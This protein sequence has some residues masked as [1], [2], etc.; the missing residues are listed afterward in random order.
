M[1]FASICEHAS[2]AYFLASTGTDQICLACSEHFRKYNWRTANTSINFPL[3]LV[4]LRSGNHF[5]SRKIWIWE[6]NNILCAQCERRRFYMIYR[7][8]RNRANFN[9]NPSMRAIAKILRAR[10][11][12]HS[13]KFCEQIEQR[14]NL[15]SSWKFLWPFDTSNFVGS[16][17]HP[18]VFKLI[19]FKNWG[20]KLTL[21][22][23]RPRNR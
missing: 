15:A 22:I 23:F 9:E 10:A 14:P 17:T 6:S 4:V 21:T 20:K 3:I 2:T 12:E 5:T 13:A 16:A 1:V 8:L 18:C 11:S 7:I 19:F